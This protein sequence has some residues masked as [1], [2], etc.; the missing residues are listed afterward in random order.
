MTDEEADEFRKMFL[1]IM[2]RTIPEG[3]VFPA[4]LARC[5]LGSA[6][7]LVTVGRM[8]ISEDPPGAAAG[9]Y[10]VGEECALCGKVPPTDV[11]QPATLQIDLASGGGFGLGVWVHSECLLQCP[12]SDRQRLIPW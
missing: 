1:G 3:V 7:D 5:N 2:E 12:A 11:R 8:T 9:V 10:R 6:S 4:E